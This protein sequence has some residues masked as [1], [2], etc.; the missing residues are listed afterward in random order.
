M[1]PRHNP[2]G[3]GPPVD[4]RPGV[5]WRAK[6]VGD[7]HGNPVA[8]IGPRPQTGP[9]NGCDRSVPQRLPCLLVSNY[10]S[11][12]DRLGVGIGDIDE[13]FDRWFVPHLEQT[14]LGN[15]L[16]VPNDE[17]RGPR[18]HGGRPSTPIITILISPSAISAVERFVG[19]GAA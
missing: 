10:L 13:E 16:D 4:R 17:R 8:V 19:V 14:E 15:L 2:I 7:Q 6:P 5:V 18:Y 12:V 9:I 1:V 3:I 11:M